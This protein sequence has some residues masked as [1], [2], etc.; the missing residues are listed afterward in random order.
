MYVDPHIMDQENVALRFASFLSDW[1]FDGQAKPVVTLLEDCAQDFSLQKS[2]K[3]MAAATQ[4]TKS[5]TPSTQQK[6]PFQGVETSQVPK[7][8]NRPQ[9]KACLPKP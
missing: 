8:A 5:L 9:R 3:A 2:I 7:A 1:L 6:P 4:L